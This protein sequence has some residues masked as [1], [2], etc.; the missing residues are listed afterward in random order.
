M[1]VNEKTLDMSLNPKEGFIPTDHF[2][3]PINK[4]S[5]L[6]DEVF[7]LTFNHFG[8]GDSN[9]TWDMRYTNSRNFIGDCQ[10]SEYCIKGEIKL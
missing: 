2:Y 4:S 9:F 8:H 3:L 5:D 10:N 7:T 6:L 1:Y